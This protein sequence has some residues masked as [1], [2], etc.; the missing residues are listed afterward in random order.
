MRKPSPSPI[1]P[2]SEGMVEVIRKYSGQRAHRFRNSRQGLIPGKECR[3]G[4]PTVAAAG[5]ADMKHV[6]LLGDS[7]FDNAAYVSGGPDVVRQL[8]SAL[9]EGW[10]ATLRAVDGGTTASV[11][12]QIEALPAD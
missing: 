6:V 7:V 5:E 8:R 9:P 10:Q 11:A 12:R 3:F 4:A 1:E 2:A